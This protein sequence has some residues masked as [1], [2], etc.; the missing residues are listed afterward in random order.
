MKILVTGANGF[1]GRHV[2]AALLA[3]G[4]QVVA[5]VRPAARVDDLGWPPSLEVFRADLRSSGQLESAFDRVDV[6]VHLAG[7][8]SGEADA[9]FAAN[10]VGTERLLAAM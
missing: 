9:Q 4:H 5:L 3:R 8:V 10:V 1:I 7:A 2:V 6:L